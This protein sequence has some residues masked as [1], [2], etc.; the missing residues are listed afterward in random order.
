MRFMTVQRNVLCHLFI[1]KA[2]ATY[3]GILSLDVF[4]QP[5][6]TRNGFINFLN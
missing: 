4:F 6:I 5:F 1:T 2:K 3:I